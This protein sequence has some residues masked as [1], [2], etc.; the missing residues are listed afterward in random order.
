ML[1]P[2]DRKF[3]YIYAYEPKKT[4]EITNHQQILSTFSTEKKNHIYKLVD[5]K[6]NS[7]S[8]AH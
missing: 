1:D 7:K 8:Y 3:D 6:S 5:N 2:I 4:N